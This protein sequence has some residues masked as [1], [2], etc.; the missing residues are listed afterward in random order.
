MRTPVHVIAQEDNDWRPSR[1]N[2]FLNTRLDQRQH[3]RKQIGA[4]VDVAHCKPN[5][6]FEKACRRRRLALEE[7]ERVHSRAG[8]DLGKRNDKRIQPCGKVTW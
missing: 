8:M 4:T 3:R 1:S 7:V 6:I 2:I 5:S